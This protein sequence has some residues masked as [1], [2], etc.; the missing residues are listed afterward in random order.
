[1][2]KHALILV[3]VAF[4]LFLVASAHATVSFESKIDDSIYVTCNFEHL[5]QIV[6]NAAEANQQLFNGSS[7]PLAI[8]GNLE[9]QGLTRVSYGFQDNTYDNVTK[10]IR[11]SF[12]IGG[13]DIISYTVNNTNL[14]R[15]YTVKTD[16]RKF[17]VQLT[18]SL[19]VDFAQHFAEQV[20][21]WR[22]IDY[23]DTSG[24]VHPAYFY[25]TGEIELLGKMSFTL[26]LPSAATSVQV[27]GDTVTFDVPS[28]FG[29][30][31][32][33]SPF[34]ILTVLLIVVA[35]ALVYRRLK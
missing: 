32:L 2:K 10:S 1:M 35:V 15:T 8:M 26:I 20:E 27:E 18:S 12:F 25:E 3:S 4:I 6:Y 19:S 16:W 34:L 14:K 29:D 22:K 13:A 21:N 9:K 24:N 31:F 11:A 17:Q 7:M 23:T 30:I 5:D 33:A 28:S